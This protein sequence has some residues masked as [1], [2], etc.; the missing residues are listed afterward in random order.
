MNYHELLQVCKDVSI[1]ISSELSNLTEN[2]TNDK[3]KLSYG[4][5]TELGELLLT[6]CGPWASQTHLILRKAFYF[7]SKTTEWNCSHEKQAQE[8]YEKVCKT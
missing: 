1:D 5:N 6:G 3:A 7:T 2:E 8:M 4:K